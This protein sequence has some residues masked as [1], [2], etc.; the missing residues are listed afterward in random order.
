MFGSSA[1]NIVIPV[2]TS[3]DKIL[4]HNPEPNYIRTEM[5]VFLMGARFH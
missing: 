2:Y 5:E 3:L 4:S 1:H